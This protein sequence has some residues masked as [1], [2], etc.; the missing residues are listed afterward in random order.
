[1][2]APSIIYL[3]ETWTH[4]RA[5]KS[6]LWTTDEA[7]FV[8]KLNGGKRYIIIYAGSKD[9]FVPNALKVQGDKK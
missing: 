1:M 9:G 7:G 3:D 2:P 5:C 4:T 8:P 6:K